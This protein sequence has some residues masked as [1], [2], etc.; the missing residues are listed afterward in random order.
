MAN[1]RP[2]NYGK[3]Y[4]KHE[5]A[6]IYLLENTRGADAL[7]ARLLKRTPGA[8]NMVRRWVNKAAFPPA[9]YNEI[10][11]H[12]AWAEKTFGGSNKAVVKLP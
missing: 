6:L 4:E 1:A 3:P 5:V 12:A 2:A 10:R 9:S 8:V 11:R 7:L